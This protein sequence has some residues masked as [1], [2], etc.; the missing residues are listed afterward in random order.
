MPAADFV[1]A[2]PGLADASAI[3]WLQRVAGNAAVTSM[4]EPVQRCGPTPCD[5]PSSETNQSNSE[6]LTVSRDL[7]EW[8]GEAVTDWPHHEWPYC[9]P[10]VPGQPLDKVSR[11][12]EGDKPNFEDAF[13][14]LNGLS[15]EDMVLTLARL[16]E[17]AR[18]SLASNL[19]LA[20]GKFHAGRLDIGLKA[21]E[22]IDSST[23]HFDC[24]TLSK[25]DEAERKIVARL[26]TRTL[27]AS[28]KPVFGA[29]VSGTPPITAG[30]MYKLR[31]AEAMASQTI[32][33]RGEA[34]PA[35]KDE[36]AID[37]IVNYAA[38]G[39]YHPEGKAV[40]INYSASPYIMHENCERQLDVQLA[41]SYKRIAGLILLKDSVI[42]GW[43]TQLHPAGEVYDRLK[44]E[45]VAMKQYFLLLGE[46]QELGKK[47]TEFLASDYGQKKKSSLGIPS[48][49]QSM[50]QLIAEDYVNL[51][52]QGRNLGKLG[53]KEPTPSQPAPIPCLESDGTTQKRS[54]DRSLIWADR[55]FQ[56]GDPSKRSP[57]KGF[58][59]LR[60][61]VVEA[62]AAVGLSWGAGHTTPHGFGGEAGDV[63]H[64]DCRE[65]G[66]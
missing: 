50:R 53:Y 43:I 2:R 21:A 18:K 54:K 20:E 39:G 30:L 10:K 31:E 24:L 29:G 65:G 44:E 22:V 49:P 37:D 9:D 35:T 66:C 52:G 5:C 12:L 42:P 16:S 36:W 64:F 19:R 27:V 57:E 11:T 13:C 59:N 26:V 8:P 45:S 51:G 25:V 47:L 41:T 32:C 48:Q 60:K 34:I 58:I 14:I 28:T 38:S 15:I 3:L 6:D 33:A 46:D 4:F 17:A 7:F 40:D 1:V 56:K 62:L 63:M 23:G 55:P 61:E